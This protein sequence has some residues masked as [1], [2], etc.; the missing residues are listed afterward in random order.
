MIVDINKANG[1][2]APK[3]SEKII[4][5]VMDEEEKDSLIEGAKKVLKIDDS[6]DAFVKHITTS[7]KKY[8]PYTEEEKAE[9]KNKEAYIIKIYEKYWFDMIWM[10]AVLV[11][12]Q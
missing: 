7:W 2:F 8:E 1:I 6:Y 3:G 5:I 9:F 11:S 4:K 10:W 12:C